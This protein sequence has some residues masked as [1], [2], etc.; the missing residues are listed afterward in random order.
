MIIIFWE[1]TPCGSYKNQQNSNINYTETH[2]RLYRH[3]AL[4]SKYVSERK[5]AKL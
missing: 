5:M 2:M 1:M 3:V 4:N